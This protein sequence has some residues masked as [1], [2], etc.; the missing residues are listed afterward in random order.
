MWEPIK[1]QLKLASS[2][3]SGLSWD[4]VVPE[5]EQSNWKTN[6]TEF[7]DYNKLNACCSPIPAD[8]QS[9]SDVRL[10]CLSDA[11]TNAGGAMVY[12]GR[13]YKDGTWSC[14]MIAAKSKMMKFTIPRNELSAILMMV[15]LGYLVKKEVS[16]LGVN[17]KLVL[18]RN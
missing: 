13:K 3:L 6:L 1:L 7:I 5:A 8:I 12:A 14:S 16:S 9:S 4:Q 18:T 10:I 11:G 17:K 15:E 2:R